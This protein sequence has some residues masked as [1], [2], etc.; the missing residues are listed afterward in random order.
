M[1]STDSTTA[2]G[3]P[4]PADTPVVAEEKLLTLPSLPKSITRL[5]NTESPVT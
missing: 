4:A 3:E 2:M 1:G 5:S